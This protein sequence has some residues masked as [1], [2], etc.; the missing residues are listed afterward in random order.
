MPHTKAHE[1]KMAAKNAKKKT[2]GRPMSDKLKGK[3]QSDKNKD[4]GKGPKSK[5]EQPKP[6]PQPKS[7][8]Q[9]ESKKEEKKNKKTRSE[10]I[11]ARADRK[12]DKEKKLREKQT[13][14]IEEGKDRKAKRIGK[15]RL[16]NQE[17]VNKLDVKSYKVKRKEEAKAAKKDG[18]ARMPDGYNMQR[19]AE[20]LGYIQ[21]LGAGRMSPGKMGDMTAM[22]MMHGDAAAKY[23]D[24]AGMYMNG[25]PK[26]E[27]ASK[28]YVGPMTPGH[29][30]APGHTHGNEFSGKVDF[31]V[32]NT[33]GA[34][35]T[36]TK[37]STSSKPSS[38]SSGSKT[39]V[40]DKGDDV[41]YNNLISSKKNMSEMKNL[42]ID[43][44]NKKAVLDYGNK[45]H[46]SRQKSN[47]G[48]SSTSSS[49]SSTKSSPDNV[50]AIKREGRYELSKI[51][52]QDNLSRHKQEMGFK[53]DSLGA[54]NKRIFDLMK[55]NPSRDK[56]TMAAIKQQGEYA[57]NVA[58]NIGRKE[59]KIPE[60]DMVNQMR[61]PYTGEFPVNKK[62]LTQEG[63]L[64]VG[65]RRKSLIDPSSESGKVDYL[66]DKKG[67]LVQQKFKRQGSLYTDIN[68]MMGGSPKMPK[69]PM[70]FGMKK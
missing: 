19:P 5:S 23:Y 35:L 41:F 20:K 34:K 42:G 1:N 68:E 62:R 43:P 37:T 22:K 59:A 3:K 63:G 53:R 32:S 38:T 25:A 26:Y 24:G 40:V 47:S 21:R 4:M 29:G 54:S 30:G 44:S 51:V 70:K 36:D 45:L 49:S 7:K 56:V 8:P 50:Q 10:R 52:G 31:K 28:S 66:T 61:N 27:G 9:P 13:K 14:A 67:N 11:K 12:F 64:Y 65:Q 60:V 6:Q 48:G 33:E 17:R 39:K 69:G 15:R 46:K 18:A 57:G 2:A 16:R 58:A 55:A